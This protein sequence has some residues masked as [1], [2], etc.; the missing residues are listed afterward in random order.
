MLK[1]KAVNQLNQ[2]LKLYDNTNYALTSVDGILPPKANVNTA[3]L[4]TKDGSVFNSARLN[5]RNVVLTVYPL[6][7]IETN[8]MALYSFFKAKK[9]VRLYLATKSRSAYVDGWVESVSGSLFDQKEKLQVSV[10]CPDPWLKAV[11]PVVQ[12]F[13]ALT[14]AATVTNNSD[15][16]TGF[17][18]E[19]TASGAVTNLTLTNATNGQ[20]LTLTYELVSGDKV[21]LNTQ[22]GEKSIRLI[23]GGAETNLLNHVN[24]SSDWI[25]LAIGANAMSFSCDSGTANLSATLTLQP[26]YEGV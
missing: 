15:D 14:H 17:V 16:E 20:S 6:G 10:I 5:N 3:A 21:I 12:A 25:A 7:A 22:R 11:T 24:V 9:P 2:E 23:R 1:V 13:D 19:F 8:R 4:A 18:C 26:I